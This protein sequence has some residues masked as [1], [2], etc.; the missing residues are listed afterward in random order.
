M[1]IEKLQNLTEQ[2]DRLL[3]RLSVINESLSQTTSPENHRFDTLRAET[4]RANCTSGC[5]A[6]NLVTKLNCDIFSNLRRVDDKTH[7][8]TFE[9]VKVDTLDGFPCPVAA[10]E[11]KEVNVKGLLNG[12]DF[13]EMQKNA[14]RTSG[15]QIISGKYDRIFFISTLID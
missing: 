10:V 11:L 3:S 15:D 7:N 6:N 5:S 12:A 2:Y 14:L 4:I 1:S 9:Y 13:N 8:V